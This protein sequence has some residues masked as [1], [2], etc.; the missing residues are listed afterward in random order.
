MPGALNLKA[1]GEESGSY[2]PGLAFNWKQSIFFLFLDVQIP[3]DIARSV[4][5]KFRGH[6]VPFLY[7]KA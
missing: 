4:T 6:F 5:Y 2:L 7:F 1:E 3:L